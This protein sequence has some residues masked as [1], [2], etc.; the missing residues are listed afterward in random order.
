MPLKLEELES[1][2]QVC[3]ELITSHSRWYILIWVVINLS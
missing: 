3:T 2:I 1:I